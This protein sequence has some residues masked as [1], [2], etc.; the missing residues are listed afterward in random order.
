MNALHKDLVRLTEAAERRAAE[1]PADS[2][3][4]GFHLAPP[5][6]WLNDPN[7]LCRFRDEYHVFYQYAPFDAGGGVKFWGHYKSRDLLAW[8]RCPVML[9]SDAPFDVHGAYSGSALCEEDGLYLYYT[10]NVKYDGDYDYVL[11]GRE[12][13][14]VVAWSPD[15]VRLGW[16]RLL[17]GPGDY[18]GGLTRHV[19]DPKVWKQDGVYYMVLGAR[20]AEDAGAAL[21]F[22]SKDKF[23]WKHINTL[24]TP[25]AFG[26]MWECPDLFEIDGQWFLAVS[27]QGAPGKG[28]GYENVY[29]S[30]YFPLFGDFRG[31]CRLG[32]FVPFDFGFDFYAPQ[33]FPDGGRRL[34]IGWMGMPDAEYT[35]P[36]AALGWQHCL[37]A[38]RELRRGGDGLVMAPAPE[39]EALRE[40]FREYVY[41]G[42]ETIELPPLSDIEIT[43]GGE[44][45]LD[46]S[47]VSLRTEHGAL[48][49]TVRE[50]GWGRG[51]RTAPVRELR[52]LRVLADTSALEFF[53]ND[54]EAVLSVRWYPEGEKRTLTLEGRGKAAVH[55]LRPLE[56]QAYPGGLDKPD[57]V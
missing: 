56:I 44:L 39:L 42:R 9:Y 34:L 5:T 13:N 1:T 6:G 48:T 37:T 18:P 14:T 28:P 11:E 40:D 33:T 23:Q 10:G 57:Q 17:M 20:T 52:K 27:P 21:V 16:K 3:R 36:T 51:S 19:R 24:R 38:P 49:L 31:D 4:P 2:W 29:A 46:L 35:N 55:R 45:A 50:G 15:G 8:E 53:A 12:N 7:G 54:G 22:A 43:C 26:Y 47:G 41:E 32:A 30:G 25:E